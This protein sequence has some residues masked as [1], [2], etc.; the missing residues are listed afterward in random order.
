[1]HHVFDETP[2]EA[3][4]L[5]FSAEQIAQE[6]HAIYNTNVGNTN[7]LEIRE[8]TNTTQYRCENYVNSPLHVVYNETLADNVAF[9]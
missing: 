3:K 5:A 4:K 6:S 2:E 1:M 9:R 7:P 8:Q